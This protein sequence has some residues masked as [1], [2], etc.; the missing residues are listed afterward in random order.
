MFIN[1]PNFSMFVFT[2]FHFLLINMTT[3]LF[4]FHKAKF[5][6]KTKLM[7]QSKTNWTGPRVQK[8]FGPLQ[9]QGIRNYKLKKKC[10]QIWFVRPLGT[11]FTYLVLPRWWNMGHFQ[12]DTMGDM[13]VGYNIVVTS[14]NYKHSGFLWSLI[15]VVDLVLGSF[16]SPQQIFNSNLKTEKK[17]WLKQN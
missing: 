12:R 3:K 9:R 7:V 4:I 13:Y 5:S 8:N 15:I 16:L 17:S 14:H 10:D 2:T 11:S 1:D 6:I